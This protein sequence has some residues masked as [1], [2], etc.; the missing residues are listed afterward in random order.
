MNRPTLQATTFVN[1]PQGDVNFGWRFYDD[2]SQTY[3]NCL[4]CLIDDDLELLQEVMLN[5]D[6]VSWEIL[7]FLHENG[8][9]LY[10]G[11]NWYNWDDIK[12]LWESQ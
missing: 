8:H 12:H 6:D 10:I 4:E 1:H 7:S 3:A 2:Y 9:G 11:D 5:G